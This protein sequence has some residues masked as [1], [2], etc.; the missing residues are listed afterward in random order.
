MGWIIGDRDQISLGEDVVNRSERNGFG[1]TGI[2]EMG[3]NQSR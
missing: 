3:D 1:Q 2:Q